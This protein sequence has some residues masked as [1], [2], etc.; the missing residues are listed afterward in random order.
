[1][2]RFNTF[3]WYTSSL[4]STIH[5]L[6]CSFSF[7]TDLVKESSGYNWCY[8]KREKMDPRRERWSHPMANGNNNICRLSS[9]Q[10]NDKQGDRSASNFIHTNLLHNNV[11]HQS[12]V[13]RLY[14][15]EYN[16]AYHHH[17]NF[18]GRMQ[19]TALHKIN[20]SRETQYHPSYMHNIVG[21]Q[22]QGQYSTPLKDN[23]INKNKPVR[24][25]RKRTRSKKHGDR[26]KR[27]KRFLFSK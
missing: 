10:Q 3:T 9:N 25:H 7:K 27:W 19:Q 17:S 18:P 23:Q 12:Q 8:S 26:A 20:S 14:S 1:M 2:F 5:P 21:A 22:R 6:P 4:P 16:N 11:H 13:N 24:K 15:H